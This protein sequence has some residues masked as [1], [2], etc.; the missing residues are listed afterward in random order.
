MAILI[1][2]INGINARISHGT[3]DKQMKYRNYELRKSKKNTLGNF[4]MKTTRGSTHADL[5]KKGR[6][7]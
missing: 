2:G 1:S 6:H 7:T 5:E 3:N 4:A